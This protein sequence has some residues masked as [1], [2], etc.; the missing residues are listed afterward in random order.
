MSHCNSIAGI[1]FFMHCFKRSTNILAAKETFF[2]FSPSV[3]VDVEENGKVQWFQCFSTTVEEMIEIQGWC[4]MEIIRYFPERANPGW[5]HFICIPNTH[6]L[7]VF[8]FK[9]CTSFYHFDCLN[10]EVLVEQWKCNESLIGSRTCRDKIC[11]Y[12]LSSLA[13]QIHLQLSVVKISHCLQHRGYWRLCRCKLLWQC[14]IC[15]V[16]NRDLQ[17]K[18]D[19]LT[20]TMVKG[21]T[22]LKTIFTFPLYTGQFRCTESWLPN[23]KTNQLHT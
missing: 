23:L 13:K 10:D 14:G 8:R 19:S 7:E 15:L 22:Q 4:N 2:F 21:W 18:E 6:W 5:S 16:F 3:H 20:G 11:S 1:L 17:L 9:K 12:L